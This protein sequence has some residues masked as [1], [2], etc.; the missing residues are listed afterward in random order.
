MAGRPSLSE[1]PLKVA[2]SMLGDP[3]VG[4]VGRIPELKGI[5]EAAKFGIGSRFSK[6]CWRYVGLFF[7]LRSAV[8]NEPHAVHEVRIYRLYKRHWDFDSP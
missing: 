8:L 3:L 6:S 2:F 1:L 7:E 4:R 5:L